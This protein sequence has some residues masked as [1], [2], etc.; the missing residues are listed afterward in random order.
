MKML[1]ICRLAKK[2]GFD[3]RT[4]VEKVSDLAKLETD[5]RVLDEKVGYLVQ[6]RAYYEAEHVHV[7]RISI[8]EV[9]EKIGMGIQELK[10]LAHISQK[11]LLRTTF[12]KTKPLRSFLRC[13]KTV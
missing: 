6:K 11:S 8:Y 1:S 4:I 7:H 13:T 9:I 5:Q 10:L 2:T 12:L 3:A